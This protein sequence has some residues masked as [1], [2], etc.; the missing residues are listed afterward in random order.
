MRLRI[1]RPAQ[2]RLLAILALAHGKRVST[3]QL[4]DRFWERPPETARA[5]IQTHVSALR[6]ALGDGVVATE[7][8]GYRLNSAAVSIDADMFDQSSS[9]CPRRGKKEATGKTALGEADRALER[10]RGDP[11]PDLADDDFARAEIIRLTEV[12]LELLETRARAL[13]AQGRAEEALPDLEGLVVEHPLR[14][15]LWEH[16]DDGALPTRTSHRGSPVPSSR[17]RPIL[18]RSVS[19]PEKQLR[20]LEE[21]ILLHDKSLNQTKH[22]LPAQL[23]MFVGQRHRDPRAHERSS[24]R[25]DSPPLP[26]QGARAR[27]G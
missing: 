21:K 18:P 6:K 20:R 11:Y 1:E 16:L 22:N 26:V 3:D 24:P 17:S 25:T 4:I 7:G 27:P 15:R 9:G 19:S 23:D 12:R 2:R 14:E 8:Y 5:A 10:W 13:I